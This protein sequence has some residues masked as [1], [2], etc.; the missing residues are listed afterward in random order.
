[1]NFS[2]KH[3]CL[4]FLIVVFFAVKITAQPPKL[5]RAAPKYPS[6]SKGAS[7]TP[8][9]IS[10]LDKLAPE[11]QVL[12]GQITSSK[13]AGDTIKTSSDGVDGYTKT[14]LR[15]I[16]GIDDAAGDPSVNL[17]LETAADIKIDDLKKINVGVYFRRGNIWYVNAPVTALAD[18]AKIGAV[19]S[20]GLMKP[21]NVPS[22]PENKLAGK[23][24]LPGGKGAGNNALTNKPT[25]NQFNKQNLTGKGVIVAVVDS[26]IDWTHPDFIRADGT[27]RVLELWDLTDDSWTNSGGKTGTKPPIIDENAQRLPGTLYTNAQLN[28]ALKNKGAVNSRDKVGHG[29]AVAGTAA[30]NGRGATE[31]QE[32]YQGIAPEADLII[33]KVGD[34]DGPASTLSAI[35]AYWAAT[36]AKEN[37]KRPAVVNLSLGS[38][39][40]A[41][42]GN[43]ETEQ[44]INAI[45]DST[46]GLGIPVVISAGNEGR[47]SIHAGGKFAPRE[48]G[49][50]N[51]ESDPVEAF[52]NEPS[53]LLGV[54]DSRDEWGLFFRSTNPLFQGADGKPAGI[55]FYK[56]GSQ[57]KIESD[58]PLANQPV[59]DKFLKMFSQAQEGASDLLLL[60]LP[61]GQY[62][63]FGFGSS[64]TV[65]SGKFDLYFPNASGASFGEGTEKRF[66]VGA[67]GGATNAITV[68]SL[69]F[70][71]EWMNTSGD[72]SRFNMTIGDIS[73]Y[74]SPGPRRDG[75][76][77]PEIVAPGRYTLAPLSNFSIPENGG[78]KS[79]MAGSAET[80]KIYATGSGR[81]LAWSGTSA[82]APFVAGVVALM[83]QKNP[84]LTPAEIKQIL[85]KTASG[86]TSGDQ[87]NNDE[88]LGYGRIEPE[89]ALK[90][91]TAAK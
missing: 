46:S 10:P 12:T 75:V 81:H 37:F 70:R 38:H 78:C 84:N 44:L 24:N 9:A 27:S 58:A 65:E 45:S 64:E 14:Q 72:V 50:I 26:G 28:A 76:T 48:A 8:R 5:D 83:L 13:S 59:F 23:F 56:I 1:M 11:L 15:E 18:L 88:R 31:N 22:P 52:V 60:Q 16:F 17:I 55:F 80:R 63:F 20:V 7:D 90:A 32:I 43:S 77:K 40:N 67:P 19:K 57:F 62:L 3:A 82:S 54:F 42:D 86:R 85:I 87:A 30:G 53:A 6:A 33:V 61:A 89:A 91:V 49:Q 51:V 69:D 47:L 4:T 66:M 68:G 41:H 21:L 39:L 2:A 29:T 34:C 79:S 36:E 74:S 73:D 25:A 35:G 71:G